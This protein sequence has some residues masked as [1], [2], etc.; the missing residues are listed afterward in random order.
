ML[1]LK[2]LEN[3]AL[4]TR[5]KSVAGKKDRC[6]T[7]RHR[8]ARV[9]RQHIGLVQSLVPV[10]AQRARALA[11]KRAYNYG[12]THDSTTGF[13]LDLTGLR[14]SR[15]H[16]ILTKGVSPRRELSMIDYTW[17]DWLVEL[18]TKIAK[19][20]ETYLAERARA[21]EW[22]TNRK[23]DPLLAPG[24]ENIDPMS[25]LYSLAQ[26]N[27]VNQYKDVFGSVHEVFEIELDFPKLRPFIPGPATARQCVVPRQEDVPIEI[28]SGACSCRRRQSMR[29]PPS[30]Q[31]TSMGS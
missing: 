19:N 4:E 10:G 23:K 27:T 29:A 26:K 3:L 25:F 15:D 12:Q 16:P 8:L 14:H 30:N 5:A 17:E 6:S 22:K 7:P 1:L 28:C 20:G 9:V 13:L 31:R 11:G 18:A 21:V 24:D 2:V